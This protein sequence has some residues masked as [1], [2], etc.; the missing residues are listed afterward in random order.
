[1]SSLENS[2]VTL[3]A[4][5]GGKDAHNAT[6][7]HY[8]ALRRALAAKCAGP[9]GQTFDEF[10]L[11][12]RI[13]GSVQSWKKRGVDNVRLQRKFRY[14]TADIFVP[15]QIWKGKAPK[16]LRAFLANEVEA[17]IRAITERAKKLK[18]DIDDVKLLADVRRAI[19]RFE[20]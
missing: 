5:V 2:L 17:A 15:T 10:A 18:V 6:K 3:G 7:E 13:D 11:V 14:A 16:V 9:Y 12:L 4:D 20:R 19:S 1:M 8:M